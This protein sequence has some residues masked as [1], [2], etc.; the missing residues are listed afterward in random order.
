MQ[1][2][3]KAFLKRI[4]MH[5]EDDAPRLIFADWLEDQTMTPSINRLG[6]SLEWGPE[7]GRFIRIQIA[8]AQM[9]D[10]QTREIELSGISRRDQAQNEYIREEQE[11]LDKYLADWMS[12]LATGAVFSRGFVEQVNVSARGLLRYAHELFAA[13]PLRHL[14]LLD[15]GDG[16]PGVFQCQFLSRLSALTVHASHIGL[17]LARSI[18]QTEHLAGIKRLHLTGNTFRDDAIEQLVASPVMANLEELD[19]GKNELGETSAQYLASFPQFSSLRELE[20]G[21]NRLGPVGA[22]TIASS[23]QF[24]N[25]KR[26][27]LKKNG[28][29]IARLQTLTRTHGFFRVPILDLSDNDLGPEGLQVLLNRIPGPIEVGANK[30]RDLDLSNNPLGDDGMRVL[31]ACSHLE[32]LQTLRLVNCEIGDEGVRVLM[33]CPHLSNVVV[34]DLSN[35]RFGNT[36]C[37]FIHETTTMRKLRRPLIPTAGISADWNR[38]IEQRYPDRMNQAW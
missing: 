1:T 30:L 23:E 37:R 14:C 12:P 9:K 13:T 33:D 22:E 21:D 31:A 24:T 6:T 20:L 7:R 17:R 10:E 19:L 18:A 28:I 29:G 35:N 8:L 26:L 27:G 38:A 3:I 36:G 25:L 15:V 16:L 11:L 5:P 4:L 32:G 34:L 2:E